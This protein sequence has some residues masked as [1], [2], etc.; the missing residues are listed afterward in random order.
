MQLHI[1]FA[2]ILLIFTKLD[3][4]CSRHK[5]R[6][7]KFDL[8]IIRSM[9]NVD[10]VNN[11]NYCFEFAISISFGYFGTKIVLRFMTEF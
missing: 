7:L 3:S 2:I 4:T 10:Y 6:H 5:Y 11:R 9:V 1:M 8:E